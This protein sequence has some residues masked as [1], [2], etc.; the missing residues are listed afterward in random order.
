MCVCEG[1]SAAVGLELGLNEWREWRDGLLSE[2]RDGK[3]VGAIGFVGDVTR[4][5]GLSLGSNR[6]EGNGTGT[7][8]RIMMTCNKTGFGSAMASSVCRK[9]KGGLMETYMIPGRPLRR[10]RRGPWLRS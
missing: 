4:M 5:L 1:N 3:C 8:I 2:L 6:S 9:Q 10:R 7:V